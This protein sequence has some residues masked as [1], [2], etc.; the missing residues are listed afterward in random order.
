MPAK[1]MS[2]I[3]KLVAAGT[4]VC[5]RDFQAHGISISD[6][7]RDHGFNPRIVYQ[8]LSGR[9]K[10]LRGQSFLIARALGMK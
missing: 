10:S 6:W 7:S 4:Q 9:R 5:A 8:V 2:S 3:D 1:P